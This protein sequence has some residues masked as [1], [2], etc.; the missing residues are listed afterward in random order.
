[1]KRAFRHLCFALSFAIGLLRASAVPGDLD[2]GFGSNGV[3]TTAIGSGDSILTAMVVQ[4]DGKIVATGYSA[5]G[6]YND[7]VVVRY[8]PNGMLDTTFNVT[9]KVITDLRGYG[10]AAFGVALQ[11]DGKIVVAGV[12][13][14]SSFRADIAIVRYK[15]DGSLD[16][17]FGPF[18]NGKIVTSSIGSGSAAYAIAIQPDGK[19]VLAGFAVTG[20]AQDFALVRYN[21]D[22]GIDGTFGDN[23]LVT[24]SLRTDRALNEYATSITLQS[25]GKILVAGA[26]GVFA[27]TVPNFV[28]VIRYNSDGTLDNGF[29]GPGGPTNGAGQGGTHNGYATGVA[30]QPDGKVVLSGSNFGESRRFFT[31]DRYSASGVLDISQYTGIGL[32]NDSAN[33]VALQGDGKIILA[34]QSYNGNTAVNDF[35]LVRYHTDGA[36][37]A[38][39]NTTGKVTT[40]IGEGNS[41]ANCVA[42][43]ADGKILLA[44]TSLS[45][46]KR[47]FTVAR[48]QA[49]GNLVAAAPSNGSFINNNTPMIT[50]MAA[51]NATVSVYVDGVSIGSTVADSGGVWS[52][53]V[54]NALSDGLHSVKALDIADITATFSNTNNGSSLFRVGK[55]MRV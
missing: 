37:D 4:P 20:L 30:L 47:V 16:N 34:G 15:A 52:F 14:N 13:E 45:G 42:I 32:S 11:G 23:G 26:G 28:A 6:A 27:G 1:M 17:E 3:A 38:G 53:A 10:D 43:Q 24:R 25:D 5:V 36:L 41:A 12:S 40:P 51:A 55:I 29:T 8:N 21:S 39:F 7:F 33:G 49:F 2:L 48:Y 35:A 31:L 18:G 46:G 22:G 9:G 54:P 44:G 19:I 50:G